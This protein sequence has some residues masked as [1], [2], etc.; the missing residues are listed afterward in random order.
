MIQIG[1]ENQVT[2]QPDP[3]V[4]DADNNIV[5]TMVDDSNGMGWVFDQNNPITI[6]NPKDFTVDWIANGQI[7]VNDNE[8]DRNRIPEHKYTLH[9]V[10]TQHQGR[11]LNFDP[12]IRDRKG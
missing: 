9:F 10:S 7:K 6:A 8:S 12:I 2:L 3:A 11:R 5:F 4:P 1:W